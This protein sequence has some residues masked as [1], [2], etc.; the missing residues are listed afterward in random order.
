M[1]LFRADMTQESGAIADIG[2]VAEATGL[3]LFGKNVASEHRRNAE[4]RE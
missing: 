3:I 2:Q 1:L 4:R